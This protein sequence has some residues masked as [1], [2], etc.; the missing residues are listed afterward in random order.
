MA[1]NVLRGQGSTHRRLAW[2]LDTAGHQTSASEVTLTS[3][4]PPPVPGPG[5]PGWLCA[6][7]MVT[8]PS[9]N[10][11]LHSATQGCGSWRRPSAATSWKNSHLCFAPPKFS[12]S[13]FLTQCTVGAA[14]PDDLSSGGRLPSTSVPWLCV[15]HTY[16]EC[17][18]AVFKIVQSN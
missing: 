11:A 3:L 10:Q 12:P 15:P 8:T 1:V 16:A 6:P 18:K 14:K 2:C 13:H 5:H 4:V 17:D 7:E 9:I